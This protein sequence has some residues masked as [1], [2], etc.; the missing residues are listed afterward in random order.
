MAKLPAIVCDSSVLIRLRKGD[1]LSCLAAL[2]DRVLIPEAV[3]REATDPAVKERIEKD[4]FEVHEVRNVLFK[5]LGRGEQEVIS[6]A[7]LENIPFVALDDLDA[8]KKADHHGLEVVSSFK[9]LALA[10]QAKVFPAVKPILD[11]MKE[12]GE[13]IKD[14]E[15]RNTLQKSG[16][17]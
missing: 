8:I 11:R 14:N 13:G 4:D 6:L 12:A 7:V 15:Y 5:V 10:K 1:A 16:E 9:L 2:F 17:W 3:Y